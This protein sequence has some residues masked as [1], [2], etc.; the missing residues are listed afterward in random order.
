MATW[1]DPNIAPGIR[2]FQLCAVKGALKLAKAGIQMN[3]NAPTPN[4]L[5][6]LWAIEMGL[7]KNAP[8]DSVIVKVQEHIDAL[9]EAAGVG[10]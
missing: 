7:L 6:Q 2:H 9:R 10:A 3:R 1:N 8:F 4:K 5:R